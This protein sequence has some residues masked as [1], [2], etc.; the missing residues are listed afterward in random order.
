MLVCRQVDSEDAKSQPGSSALPMSL[1]REVLVANTA[2]PSDSLPMLQIDLGEV[3]Q[4]E[5]HLNSGSGSLDVP[6]GQFVVIP[7][8]EDRQVKC[9]Y[10]LLAVWCL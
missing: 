8:P 9:Y 7:T 6:S 2:P 3:R 1:R 4:V 5:E 10:I